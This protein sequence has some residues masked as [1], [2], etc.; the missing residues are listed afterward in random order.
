MWGVLDRKAQF[1]IDQKTPPPLGVPSQKPSTCGK[2]ESCFVFFC[3]GNIYRTGPMRIFL[4]RQPFG[5]RGPAQNSVFDSF[6]CLQPLHDLSMFHEDGIP[7]AV[8]LIGPLDGLRGC[9]ENMC[10]DSVR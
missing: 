3:Q 1:Q 4:V 9:L 8:E 10:L 2:Q 6:F 7:S 5:Q